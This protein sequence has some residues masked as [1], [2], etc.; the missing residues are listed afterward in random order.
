M[1]AVTR[2]ALLTT[3]TPRIFNSRRSDHE[4]TSSRSGGGIWRQEAGWRLLLDSARFS[5]PLVAPG[6]LQRDAV[7]GVTSA[8]DRVGHA[9][10]HPA[11]VIEKIQASASRGIDAQAHADPAER[12]EEIHDGI[13]RNVTPHVEAS[14]RQWDAIHGSHESFEGN[15]TSRGVGH[16]VDRV[17]LHNEVIDVPVGAV[18]DRQPGPSHPVV[19]GVLQ[20]QDLVLIE[21]VERPAAAGP[22]A[23]KRVPTSGDG[24]ATVFGSF[25]VEKDDAGSPAPFVAEWL[26]LVDRSNRTWSV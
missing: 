2:P 20:R 9:E 11:A 15:A 22:V 5:A 18:S 3:R 12:I 24:E 25:V 7:S 23:T 17:P 26:S 21:L 16:R 19:V 8:P 10:R 6:L 14:R 4:Q 1:E 13:F